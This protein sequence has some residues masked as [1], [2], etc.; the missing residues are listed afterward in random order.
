[1]YRQQQ[2][3]RGGYNPP[4]SNIG[5]GVNRASDQSQ[6]PNTFGAGA[7]EQARAGKAHY[8]DQPGDDD[9]ED[10]DFNDVDEHEQVDEGDEDGVEDR[11][12]QA[13]NVGN[14]GLKQSNNPAAFQAKSSFGG[15]SYLNTQNQ[16]AYF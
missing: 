8:D 16:S 11:I 3:N 6:W 15:A 10:D 4:Q 9:F 2:Q 14:P 1:M 5:M 12:H 13:R 7:Q